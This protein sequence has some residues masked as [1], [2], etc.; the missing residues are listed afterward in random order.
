MGEVSGA[1]ADKTSCSAANSNRPRATTN[2]DRARKTANPAHTRTRSARTRTRNQSKSKAAT[3]PKATN[4]TNRV[5]TSKK[6]KPTDDV[7]NYGGGKAMKRS[8][9]GDGQVPDDVTEDDMEDHE[10]S[11]NEEEK[12]QEIIKKFADDPLTAARTYA[13]TH[14]LHWQNIHTRLSNEFGEGKGI[15]LQDLTKYIPHMKELI[16]ELL[17]EGEKV[18]ASEEEEEELE[19]EENNSAQEP[20]E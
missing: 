16:E 18:N 13:Q 20:E 15:V 12:E 7:V 9:I 4:T 1:G 11:K 14:T 8:R 2:S 19:V 6:R 17:P 3:H 5:R 10:R